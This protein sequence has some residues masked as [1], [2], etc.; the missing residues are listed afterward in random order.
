MTTAESSSWAEA[1]QN[2]HQLVLQAALEDLENK[3]ATWEQ[4][5]L[6]AQATVEQQRQQVA[7]LEGEKRTL[8][9]TVEQLS[10]E[11]LNLK[12]Q[13][14]AKSAQ[15][16]ALEE[17]QT[18]TNERMDRL[19]SEGDNLRQEIR[20]VI[21]GSDGPPSIVDNAWWLTSCFQ[22]LFSFCLVI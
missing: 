6:T 2:S 4:E 11:V 20:H 10:T 14:Q 22:T 8:Q 3:A 16:Q 13:V 7:T 5:L 19:L 18:Q 9:S 1:R 12:G 21:S 15:V 17:A